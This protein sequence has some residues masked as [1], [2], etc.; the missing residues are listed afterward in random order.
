MLGQPERLPDHPGFDGAGVTL[1]FLDS[2]Y[3]PHPDLTAAPTWPNAPEWA[4]STPA[5]WR[6][7]A[8]TAPR[9]VCITMST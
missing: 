9:C 7:H 3:Y 2:G 8:A 6:S 5:Q 1:A 4:G